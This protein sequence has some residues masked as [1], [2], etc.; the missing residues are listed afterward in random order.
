MGVWWTPFISGDFDDDG[1]AEVALK[2]APYA[3]T[4]EEAVI[5]EG[6]FVLA[7]GYEDR[8]PINGIQVADARTGQ[9]IWGHPKP[10]LHILTG[11]CSP[12][13][14]HPIPATSFMTGVKS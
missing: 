10:T 13:S 1:K 9:M 4:K 5:A 8:Q 11:V 2:M 6:G 12:T 3:R 7:Y 14:T